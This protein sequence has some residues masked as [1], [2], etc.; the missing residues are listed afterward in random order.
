M[1]WLM[2]S[3]VSLILIV[4]LFIIIIYAFIQTQWGAQKTSEWLTQY[5]DYDI[6]F[7]GIEH[8]L[9]QPEQV[10]VHDLL[11]NPK[12]DK[13]IVSAKSAQ[14]RLNWQF[15][16]TP[17]HLQKITLENGN[18]DFTNKTPSIPLSADIL[19]FKNMALRSEKADFSF[20]AKKI[21]G[22]ITPWLPTSTDLIGAGHF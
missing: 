7:S 17:S 6:R 13:A 1:R 18:I 19:Q 2:K 5:T 4:I 12:Q 11:I 21:T 3:L 14:I 16:T 8:D 10:I 9:M 22:G 15:F 20:D